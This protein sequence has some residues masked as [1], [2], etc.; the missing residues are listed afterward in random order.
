MPPPSVADLDVQVLSLPM[1][2]RFRGLT[3]REVVLVRGPGG[4]AEFSPF[5]EYDDAEATSWWRCTLEAA[6]GGWPAPVRE[7]VPVNA[8]VP[9]IGPGE[10]PGV[11]D[12]FPGCTTA[13][14]KVAERGQS[15]ED[16]LARLSAVRSV[17]GSSGKI[18]IDVNGGWSVDDAVTWLPRYDRVAGGLEYAEQPCAT[19][20]ELAVVRR[21]VEVPIAADE[22]IRRAEDPL[23]VAR[24]QAADVAVLKVQP[25]GGVAACLRIAEQIG[26]PVVVSSALETSVGIAAGVALAAVLPSLP[27]ACGLG[28]VSLFTRDVAVPPLVPSSGH[29]PVGPIL[30]DDD[31]LAALAAPPETRD[32]WLARLDRVQ[33]LAAEQ[34]R[35]VS[36]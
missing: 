28:T 31:A 25:L 26:L 23:R 13:K 4:W 1:R 24:L 35:R 22:S 2:T 9:A 34:R 36:R 18:R 8:T 17:L 3:T 19:V 5:R 10:V 12:R 29:L 6:S 32:W 14:V 21:R 27:Y 20:E 15:H 33:R 11:L 7:R 30:P 16:D